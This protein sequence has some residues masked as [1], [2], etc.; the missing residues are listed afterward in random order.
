M[1]QNTINVLDNSTDDKEEEGNNSVDDFD[2][3][4]H[5]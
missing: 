5:S 2:A 4:L 1:D 3:S